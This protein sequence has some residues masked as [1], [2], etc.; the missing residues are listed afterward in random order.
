MILLAFGYRTQL[1]D[2]GSKTDVSVSSFTDSVIEITYQ[3]RENS[4]K[5]MFKKI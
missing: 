5:C 3:L 2:M 4:Y 1:T